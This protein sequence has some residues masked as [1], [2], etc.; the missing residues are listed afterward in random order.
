MSK[1]IRQVAT[2]TQ[3]RRLIE[4]DLTQDTYDI[5]CF[6]SG[7]MDY[8]KVENNQEVIYNEETKGYQV[9]THPECK[10]CHETDYTLI[11]IP[12]QTGLFYLCPDC[13]DDVTSVEVCAE[14][15]QPLLTH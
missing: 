11:E 9:F 2:I 14:C 12:T 15:E 13:Y 8:I 1:V 6:L 3:I 4:Q 5:E 7:L 10:V